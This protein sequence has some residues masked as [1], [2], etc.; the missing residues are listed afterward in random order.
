ML[1]TGKVFLGDW[2]GS[3]RLFESDWNVSETW[4][5]FGVPI[6]G[7]IDIQVTTYSWQSIWTWSGAYCQVAP[8]DILE[9]ELVRW[10]AWGSVWDTSRTLGRL[11]IYW[12]L[13][14]TRKT[15]MESTLCRKSSKEGESNRD[16]MWLRFGAASFLDC[17]FYLIL[18]L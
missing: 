5:K 8:L 10:S 7:S 1:S 3:W 4:G 18:R 12:A 14:P 6:R 13:A 15:R 16:G 17:F 2:E 9:R 11:S